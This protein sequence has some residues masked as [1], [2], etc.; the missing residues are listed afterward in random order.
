MGLAAALGIVNAHKGVIRVD[1]TPGEGTRFLVLLPASAAARRPKPSVSTVLVV[2]DEE[3]VRKTARVC[4][5]KHGYRVLTAANGSEAVER[6]RERAAEIDAMILDLTM[7]VMGGEEALRRLRK[8]GAN[9]PVILSSGYTEADAR[10]RF[11]ANG[12]ATYVQKP[13]TSAQLM[14]KLESVLRKR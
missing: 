3:I 12:L 7:P 11:G 8:A 4:L 13:Y 9:M 14:E 5:E 10:R 2:D 1:S 6:F